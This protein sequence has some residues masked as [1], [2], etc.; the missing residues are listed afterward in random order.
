MFLSRRIT[1]E[2][3]IS[4]FIIIQNDKLMVFFEEYDNKNTKPANF[5][6]YLWL[7]A[8]IVIDLGVRIA[9]TGDIPFSVGASLIP[10]C[11]FGVVFIASRQF[12]STG[13]QI[14][15]VILGLGIFYIFHQG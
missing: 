6:D 4:T 2:N 5:F 7:I 15:Y 13:W 14:I 10:A 1:D 11:A 8:L 3:S 12:A 9:K